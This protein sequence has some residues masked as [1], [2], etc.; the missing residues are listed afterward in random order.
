MVINQ[1]LVFETKMTTSAAFGW[2]CK[3]SVENDSLEIP[4]HSTC[5]RTRCASRGETVHSD[6]Q[7]KGKSK[8]HMVGWSKCQWGPV[9]LCRFLESRNTSCRSE[10][11]ED[12]QAFRYSKCF[13]LKI[14]NNSRGGDEKDYDLLVFYLSHEGFRFDAAV[15]LLP[16]FH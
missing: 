13:P 15:I 4:M 11:G 12:R 5:Q 8:Q 10:D 9:R 7:I 3:P 14:Q 1:K 2:L 16:C 6:C